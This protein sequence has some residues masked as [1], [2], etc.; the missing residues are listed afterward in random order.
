MVWL[1]ASSTTKFFG[2]PP[3]GSPKVVYQPEPENDTVHDCALTHA[4]RPD[5][6]FAS[7]PLHEPSFVKEPHDPDVR[8]YIAYVTAV[9]IV[10]AG[11]EMV[12]EVLSAEPPIDPKLPPLY[13]HAGVAA[14]ARLHDNKRVT[15]SLIRMF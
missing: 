1:H 13:P 7:Y 9:I 14:F 5:Q 3:Q 15:N 11:H 8:P 10:F 4:V 6:V 12:N 2:T